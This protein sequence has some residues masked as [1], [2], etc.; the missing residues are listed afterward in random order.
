MY[1]D[2]SIEAGLG[3]APAGSD[4][5]DDLERLLAAFFKALSEPTRVRV[6]LALTEDCRPVTQI[7]AVTRLP[8][9]LVS[10]HLRVLRNAGLARPDRRGSF[11]YY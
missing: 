1:V 6:L 2:E 7:A 4:E 5:T 3:P 9:P 11:V 10:H 8:Q